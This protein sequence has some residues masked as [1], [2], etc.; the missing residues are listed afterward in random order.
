MFI[1]NIFL[2]MIYNL[3]LVGMPQTANNPINKNILYAPFNVNEKSTYINYKLNTQQ[4]NQISDILKKKN[5]L[6]LIP[7]SL[8]D[9]QYE[10]KDYYLSINI[11]NCT[12][13]IFDFFINEPATRCEINTYVVNR[14]EVKGTLIMDYIS[15]I[16]SMDADK[17]FKA[18][19]KIMFKNQDNKL[20][21]KAK[22]KNIDLD[23]NIDIKYKN[24]K[25]KPILSD[26]L[27]IKTE[28]I[29]YNSGIYD[30][31]YFDSTFLKNNIIICNNHDINFKFYDIEFNNIHS[32]FYF[33]KNINFIGGMWY[34]I[35][36]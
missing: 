32:V 20:Y 10:N 18:P 22:N 34:N 27:I 24:P 9:Y 15:N 16:L 36:Q 13:P 23:F 1:N 11:Y 8:F 4:V 14:N 25:I 35:F 2:K 19:G 17:I 28:N 6:K 26:S 3:M 30:K 7:T 5:N 12:S 31:V 29:F 33:E 21:G